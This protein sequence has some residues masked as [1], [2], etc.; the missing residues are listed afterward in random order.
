MKRRLQIL[1]EP[2]LQPR[3][4]PPAKPHL[5][6]ILEDDGVVAVGVLLE[7]K[8]RLTRASGKRLVR[9]RGLEPPPGCP[10]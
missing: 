3:A 9:K 5:G 6:A 4:I 2:I 10:D 8:R 1:P 7:L